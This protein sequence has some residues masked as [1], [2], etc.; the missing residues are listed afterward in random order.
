MEIPAFDNITGVLPPYLDNPCNPGDLSPY[1]CG[2]GEVCERFSTSPERRCILE[3]FLNFRGELI[4]QGI[5]GFQR[6]VADTLGI[7]SGRRRRARGFGGPP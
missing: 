4:A 6:D 5:E 7:R 3:G 1:Y 2:I